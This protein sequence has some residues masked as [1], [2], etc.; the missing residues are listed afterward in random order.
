MQT[1]LIELRINLRMLLCFIAECISF[2]G[3]FPTILN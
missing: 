1:M 3:I 2:I